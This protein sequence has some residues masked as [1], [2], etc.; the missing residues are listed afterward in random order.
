MLGLRSEKHPIRD[1]FGAVMASGTV[2]HTDDTLESDD[3]R[4]TGDQALSDVSLER[5]EVF[6]DAASGTDSTTAAR[7]RQMSVP[8]M[9]AGIEKK[10]SRTEKSRK[11]PRV[12][13][14][15]GNHSPARPKEATVTLEAIRR[16][17]EEGNKNVI[18]VMEARLDQMERRMEKRLDLLEADSM[19]KDQIIK[20]LQD[21]IITQKKEN[22]ELKD[23]LNG[24]DHNRRL[25][26]LILTSEEF[27]LRQ[28]GEDMEL[29]AV[30]L[31]NRRLPGLGLS[32]RDIQICH[33]LQGDNKC[34][35]KFFKRNVRDAVFERRFE[36]FQRPGVVGNQNALY[37]TES[38]I[39]EMS[40]YY[41]ILLA[42][43]KN[44]NGAKVAQVFSRRGFVYCRKTKGG[45]NIRIRSEDHLLQVLGGSLPPLM[46]RPPTGRRGVPAQRYRRAEVPRP[47]GSV[48]GRGLGRGGDGA[49]D[50]ALAP[51][52]GRSGPDSG[53]GSGVSGVSVSAGGSGGSRGLASWRRRCGCLG[54]GA[55]R[56]WIRSESWS[57][58]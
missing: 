33:R 43:R 29:R 19:K 28:P 35:I 52:E 27:T 8:E 23:R 45:D 24:I 16:L 17:I 37:I 20:K 13:H 31:L 44:E 55:V 36:L 58:R 54:G 10:R 57:R 2:H 41:Q 15:R 48:S 26:S 56:G 5:D 39:P 3:E 14:R 1:I 21:Q 11:S 40:R 51:V 32:T 46:E 34:I 49:D 53:P 12:V 47:G 25:S 42:A 50:S 38:L 4:E 30:E 7:K 22:D 18:S 6:G 9:V